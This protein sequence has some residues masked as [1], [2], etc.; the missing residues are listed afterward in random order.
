M[1]ELLIIE[2]VNTGTNLDLLP[3]FIAGGVLLAAVIFGVIMA[4]VS[5][6]K[7]KKRKAQKKNSNQGK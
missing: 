2:N 4:Q 1:L 7:K 3:I 5:K 6:N